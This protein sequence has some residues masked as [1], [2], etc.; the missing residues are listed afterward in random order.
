M[1]CLW[2]SEENQPFPR[3]NEKP[4]PQ[5]SQV[6]ERIPNTLEKLENSRSKKDNKEVLEPHSSPKGSLSFV[7]PAGI[8][9][10]ALPRLAVRISNL[11][12]LLHA[13]NNS[14]L[15]AF[16]L[17]E[18]DPEMHKVV[19]ISTAGARLSRRPEPRQQLTRGYGYGCTYE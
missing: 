6:M 11:R 10:T 3:T 2:R 7:A 18:L 5:C 19:A 14:W 4:S 12:I 9:R 8:R 16:F 13:R 17:L 15:A 1:E